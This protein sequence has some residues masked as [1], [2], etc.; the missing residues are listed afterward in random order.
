MNVPSGLRIPPLLPLMLTDLS[1]D[2]A[3]VVRALVLAGF[4]DKDWPLGFEFGVSSFVCSFVILNSPL[5]EQLRPGCRTP[6]LGARRLKR[7]LPV[8]LPTIPL[9]NRSSPLGRWAKN[10]NDLFTL[11]IKSAAAGGIYFPWAKNQ[12]ELFSHGGWNADWGGSGGSTRI[13]S[14]RIELIVCPCLGSGT[15]IGGSD[16]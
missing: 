12:I 13:L 10:K 15:R 9:Y 8:F 7:E 2:R 6:K 4:L 5:G 3:R 16:G 1:V 11:G 14:G